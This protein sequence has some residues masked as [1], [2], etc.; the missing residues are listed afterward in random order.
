MLLTIWLGKLLRLATRLTGGGGSALPGYVIERLNRGFLKRCLTRLPRDVIIVT[1]TNGKTTTTKLISDLLSA[2][3]L[4]VLTNRSGGNFVRGII[5]TIVEKISWVGS[6]PYDIAVFEQDEAYAVRFVRQYKPRAVVALNVGRDQLDRFGEIDR[7]AELIGEVVASAREFV[8]L[9]A[10][11]PRIAGLRSKIKDQT[12]IAW[13]GHAEKMATEF[14]TDD[15]HHAVKK[16][17]YYRAANIDVELKSVVAGRL[18][19]VI[20]DEP[21]NFRSNLEGA[22]NGLNTAAAIATV[23]RSYPKASTETISEALAT[24]AP[25]FG[26][27]EVIQLKNGGQLKLQLVKNP[28]SFRHNLRQLGRYDAI[29]I[30][31]NDDYADGRDVSWLWD[32]D[33]TNLKPSKVIYCGGTRAYDMAV[34]LKY[35]EVGT[36]VVTPRVS[37]FLSHI[38]KDDGQDK[39]IFCTYTAMLQL[40]KLVKPEAST[41]SEEGL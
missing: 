14:V 6:L 19:L 8:V 12:A 2:H 28:A 29:G 35:D 9:N 7:T 27:G 23:I 5:S 30:A 31:I 4:R 18:K 40:R 20:N 16:P 17:S 25:A 10:N 3:D 32:V 34:R 41:M 37:T 11:D 13:F 15:Q 1:G 26:R 24:A 36:Q 39:V 38:L 33:F 21:Y 22:Q